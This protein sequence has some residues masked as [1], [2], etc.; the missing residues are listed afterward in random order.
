MDDTKSK[1]SISSNTKSL[2]EKD[3]LPTYRPVVKPWQRLENRLLQKTAVFDLY[4]NRLRSPSSEYEDDFYYIEVVDW[5]NIVPIT[6]DLKVVMVEQFRFGVS[7]PSLEIP[8]GM[9]SDPKEEPMVAALREMN[10]ETGYK[11]ES[12]DGLGFIH[13]NPA[14]QTNQNYMFYA[15][16]VESTGTQNLDPAE[17]I[18]VHLIDLKDIPALIREHKITHTLTVAAFFRYFLKKEKIVLE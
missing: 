3:Q 1:S 17:D 6:A 13:P 5:V 4:V 2:N 14:I 11:A 8:G 9:I 12:A 10:E 7:Q 15:E 18:V 16:N